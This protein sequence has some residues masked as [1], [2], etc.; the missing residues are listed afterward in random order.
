VTEIHAYE[1]VREQVELRYLDGVAA[2]FPLARRAWAEQRTR[3]ETMAVIAQRIAE[4]DGAE[5]ASSDDP[6]VF[7]ARVA[8]LATDLVEPARSRAYDELG[9]GRRALSLAIRWL[10]SRLTAEP[11]STGTGA[12]S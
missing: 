1:R 10:R 12:A 6:A 5:P 9:D 3:S 2:D 11:T 4:L 7:E 8:P